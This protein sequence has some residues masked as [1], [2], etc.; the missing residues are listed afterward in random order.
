[1]SNK[2]TIQAAASSVELVDFSD[3]EALEESFAVCSHGGNTVTNN[4]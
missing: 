1:M 4:N 2:I 3:I